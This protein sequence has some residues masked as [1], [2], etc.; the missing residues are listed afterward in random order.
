MVNNVK[1]LLLTFYFHP[2]LSAGSFRAEAL[3][4][5]L[6]DQ[7][8]AGS[9]ID[10]VTTLPNR[11]VGYTLDV[12]ETEIRDGL[13]IHRVQLPA[14]RNGVMDQ[15]FAFMSYVRNALRVQRKGNFDLVI[16]TSG[17]L[18][19][20]ILAAWIASRKKTLLYLDIRDIFV[21]TISDIFPKRITLV[22]K[23]VFSFLEKWAIRRAFRINLVSRGFENYFSKRYPDKKFVY[24]TNG[25]DAEFLSSNQIPKNIESPK[26]PFK[27]L[28]AGNVGEGQGLHL[29]LPFLALRL[30]DEVNFKIIGGGGLMNL[31]KEKCAALSLT[32]VEILPPVSRKDLL[33]EYEK[34]DVL[35]LHLNDFDAFKKVLPSK[36]FE[37]AALGKPIW[38][39]VNGYAQDFLCTEVE[40]SSVFRPC[41]VEGAI[42]ALSHL[43][44]KTTHRVA[45]LQK[46]SRE[47]IMNAMV[48][49]ILSVRE[50]RNYLL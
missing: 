19:T 26:K 13:T 21:D 10:V 28:Y 33:C 36:I 43:S 9:H 16:A 3:V 14:H 22:A 17:R 1:I 12:A 6:Q 34:A 50:L 24:F 7:L 15:S 27:V 4:N 42:T 47:N 11:Y 38:A 41:D 25:I 49:D 39:G 40:N 23:P 8:P 35:F 44:L 32:N 46:Y 45:F 37:Y 18:M 48:K 5:A 2:D 29:I 31:L 30:K 20:A